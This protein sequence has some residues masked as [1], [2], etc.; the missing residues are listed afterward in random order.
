MSDKKI[1]ETSSGAGGAVA[2]AAGTFFRTRRNRGGK[3]GAPFNTT[4][5]KVMEKLLNT[6]KKKG[7]II[8]SKTGV[9]VKKQNTSKGKDLPDSKLTHVTAEKKSERMLREAIR[10]LVLLNRIKYHEDQVKREIEEQQLRKVIRFLLKEEKSGQVFLTTGENNAA[11]FI[12]NIKSTTVDQA[13]AKLSSSKEQRLAFRA[14]YL[15]KL[16]L[17]LDSLD[18]QHVIL[19]PEDKPQN[20]VNQESPST[21]N[22]PTDA[23]QTMAPEQPAMA[24][25]AP[26]MGVP[27]ARRSDRMMQEQ[28]VQQVQS[29]ASFQKPDTKRLQQQVV[30]TQLNQ[31]N[32]HPT[33]V[34]KAIDVLKKDMPQIDD[35]YSQLTFKP[36]QMPDGSITSDRELFRKMLFGINGQNDGNLDIEFDTKDKAVATS[37]QPTATPAEPTPKPVPSGTSPGE[38]VQI[39]EPAAEEPAV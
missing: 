22:Q 24:S 34:D 4:S 17:Y 15:E 12:N 37:D 9:V 25:P 18:Q 6:K 33:G 28:E 5:E 8:P 38:P 3:V 29:P 36:L 2:G 20:Q 27:P 19:H 10:N 35:L 32:L 31:P 39:Q 16:K 1:N 26:E 30:A 21:G 23:Q 7:G 11:D 13:Y 14:T